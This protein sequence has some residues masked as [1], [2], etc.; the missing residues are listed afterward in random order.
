MEWISLTG[1][2]RLPVTVDNAPVC[3]LN[4]TKVLDRFVSFLSEAWPTDSAAMPS[5]P[6]FRSL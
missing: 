3:I 6:D 1:S 4:S 2:P 5:T